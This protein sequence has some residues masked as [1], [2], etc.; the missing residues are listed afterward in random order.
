MVCEFSEQHLRLCLV[1][2]S[3]LIEHQNINGLFLSGKNKKS[4]KYSC[5]DLCIESKLCSHSFPNIALTN[6]FSQ[7]CAKLLY[8]LAVPEESISQ[9]C[10][11]LLTFTFDIVIECVHVTLSKLTQFEFQ[12]Y[13]HA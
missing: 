2:L 13:G 7:I 9:F 3:G 5:T 12:S 6:Y 8:L 4:W 11:N 10:F 1:V